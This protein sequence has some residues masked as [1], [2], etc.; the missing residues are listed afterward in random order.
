MQN[1]DDIHAVGALVSM[2]ANGAYGVKGGNFKIFERF[3]DAS[4]A[5][6]HLNSTVSFKLSRCREMNSSLD[7]PFGTPHFSM[8]S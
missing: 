4:K 1:I 8:G 6:L 2:A 3:I 7:Q 5:K